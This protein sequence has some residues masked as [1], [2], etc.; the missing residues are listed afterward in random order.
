MSMYLKW[1]KDKYG[2]VPPGWNRNQAR[3]IFQD[4]REDY[5]Y[6]DSQKIIEYFFGCDI[7]GH[8]VGKLR[9][10]YGTLYQNMLDEEEDRQER[11]R[12]RR[13]TERKVSGSN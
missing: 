1:Y 7:R 8:A 11:M 10:L 9:S 3:Y 13:E 12:L 6:E 4:M 2:T 5:G